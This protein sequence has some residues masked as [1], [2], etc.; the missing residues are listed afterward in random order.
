MAAWPGQALEYATREL[1]GTVRALEPVPPEEGTGVVGYRVADALDQH[2]RRA[3]QACLGPA[4]L[5]NG[6][7]EYSTRPDDLYRLGAAAFDRGLYRHAALL[8]KRAIIVGG[9]ADAA[10]RLIDLLRAQDS[11]G[12]HDGAYWAISHVAPDNPGRMA[13]LLQKLCAAG[14]ELAASDLA[15]RAASHVALDDPEG[16][17]QL[18]HELRAAGAEEAAATLLARHPADQVALDYPEGVA[19]LL[20]ELHEAEAE[21]VASDLADSGRQPGRPR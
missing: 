19:Q 20:H 13:W 15:T 10:S 9:G 8:W 14:G 3:R 1:K 7:T 18:L 5:W 6:L 16:V 2:G 4:S 21:G 11:V 17:A 12:A